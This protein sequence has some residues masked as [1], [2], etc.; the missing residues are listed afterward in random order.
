MVRYGPIL[1]KEYVK[2][3]EITTKQRILAAA[4]HAGF[5]LGGVGFL[6]AL[7]ISMFA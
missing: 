7:V 6:V 5:Y 2:M 3:D 4:A 1:S